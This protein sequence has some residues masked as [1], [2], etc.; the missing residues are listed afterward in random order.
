MAHLPPRTKRHPFLKY[1][2]LEYTDADI[3]DFEERINEDGA[4]RMIRVVVLLDLDAPGRAA[5][6]Y[7]FEVAICT[8]NWRDH[9][10]SVPDCGDTGGFDVYIYAPELPIIDMD[11]KALDYRSVWKLRWPGVAD[12]A[13]REQPNLRA[14]GTL[15]SSYHH[16][17]FSCSR[18]YASRD[19]E[20]RRGSAMD[21]REKTES[22]VGLV[23][24]RNDSTRGDFST[25]EMHV[26][27]S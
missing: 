1:Q 19:Y 27:H 12:G 5:A 25:M 23:E 2:G 22:F 20:D 17:P 24:N 10:D 6:L 15:I 13:H 3:A 14:L 16:P 11:T 26:W 18:T 4:R 21:C 9:F 8:T 7:F